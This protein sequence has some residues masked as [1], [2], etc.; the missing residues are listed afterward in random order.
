MYSYMC[1]LKLLIINDDI[2]IITAY[3]AL[4]YALKC[5]YENKKLVS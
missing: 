5:W 1:Y 3:L 2:Y 4:E